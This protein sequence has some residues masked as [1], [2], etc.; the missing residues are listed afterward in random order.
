MNLRKD[1]QIS[2]FVILCIL[3]NYFGKNAAVIWKLPIW[4]DSVGTIFAAYVLGPVCGAIV[5][6]TVN[7]IYGLK[8]PVSYIYAFTS[9]A[10]GVAVGICARKRMFDSL[11]RV[12]ETGT[13]LTLISVAMSTPF[14]CIL[15]QGQTG[16]YWGDGILELLKEW[17]VPWVVASVVAEVFLDFLDKIF[18]LLILY[19]ILLAVRRLRRKK[20]LLNGSWIALLL[21]PALLFVTAGDAYAAQGRKTE[22]YNSYIQTV[23]SN[24]NGL[25]SGEANDIVSTSNGVLWIG[26]YAGLYRYNGTSFQY[27]QDFDTVKNVNDLY[28]DEEGR[29]WIGT[30]DD[31]LSICI[32][33][34]ITNTLNV[35]NG[36]PSNSVRS[37]AQ[38]SGGRYFVGTSGSLA[39]V[40]LSGGIGI[41]DVIPEIQY[42]SSMTADDKEHIAAVTS[43]GELFLIHGLDICDRILTDGKG[44]NFSC[45]YFD[46]SGRLYVGTDK[47]TLYVYRIDQ[48][49]EKLCLEDKIQCS[50]ITFMNSMEES[51]DGSLFICSDDGVAYL[52]KNGDYHVIETGSFNSSIDH[53]A[54]DYQGNLWFS[55]SRLGIMKLCKSAFSEFYPEMGLSESVVNAVTRWNGSMYCGTD[56]GLD[57]VN[58]Q[59]RE[60]IHNELTE[61]LE[62]IRIR[63]IMAD[64]LNNL[65]ICSY[66]KGMIC[67][68]PDGKIISY[69][70]ADGMSGSRYRSA[71][72][73][74]DGTI[75]VSGDRGLSY[76]SGSK[77]VRTII[78][79]DGLP[80]LIVLSLLEMKDGTLLAGTDGGGICVIRDGIV[81]RVIDREDGLGSGVIL[82][83]VQDKD[84]DGIFVVTSNGLAYM[85]D[86]EHIRRLSEFPYSNNYDLYDN[87]EGKV[88]VTGSA[89]IHVINKKNLLE[90]DEKACELLNYLNGLRGTL[91]ANAWSYVDTDGIWYIPNGTGVTKLNLNQYRSSVR[92]YR[93]LLNS[94]TV[95][96]ITHSIDRSETIRIHRGATVIEF[97]PEVVNYSADDPYIRYY[98]EGYDQKPYELS[99]SDLSVITYTNLPSGEYRLHLAIL[100]KNH[101]KI[102][103]ERIYNIV[104]EKEL[105]DNLW[106]KLYFFVEL[107]LII[108]WITWF[109]TR[110]MYQRTLALQKREIELAKEQVRM[111][112]ETILAIAATVDAKDANTSHHSQRV[113]EYSVMI[114]ERLGYDE[115][116]LDYLKKAAMMHDIGKIA[117]PDSV[118]NKPGRLTDEEFA[119]MKSHTTRG[120]EILKDFTLIPHVQEGALYHHERYDGRGYMHGLKGEDI[121]E[122]ARIIGIADAFDAMTANRVYRKKLDFSVVLEEI[123]K[124]K[125]TQFDPKM[126]DIMLELIEEGKINVDK[127][128]EEA[129]G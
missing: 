68:D 47:D 85:E 7:I 128:Y 69:T 101:Q 96:G 9:I 55:S 103:E 34:S 12:A 65:W 35:D 111:G 62:G 113:S 125:G 77:V 127:L 26:T 67:V 98:L 10:S 80:N 21:C 51:E 57:I 105:Y 39:V 45:A 14:N 8:D 42:A 121:P 44:E 124:G 110:M 95:D 102:L 88:F 115:E 32:N 43:A 86:L 100:D 15:Y 41:T 38:Q 6:C 122:Y 94:M 29:L 81:E 84:A 20:M 56:N 3:I 53:M 18:S 116:E 78:D 93:M 40:S 27:M 114:G 2:I 92:S 83:L 25:L 99:Q 33:E 58:T 89:G 30:N 70:T 82:R 24:Q 49:T 59:T 19:L 117:I 63:Y 5:G 73:L 11:F 72:E 129:Q 109:I 91:T 22:D 106:F 76:I 79:K 66:G 118:L 1:Y 46:Q 90:D 36:L 17:G 64:S 16:N 112:N 50:G 37:V 108:A 13:I 52:D 61:M 75:V 74:Q 31:G 60:I 4:L 107:V 120:A 23:Y 123:R 48:D 97:N 126:A 54:I 28:V 87:G 71:I 104:K 119:I